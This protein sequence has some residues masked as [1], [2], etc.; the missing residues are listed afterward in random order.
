VVYNDAGVLG[1][2]GDIFVVM[3][4][5]AGA[6]WTSPYRV[7]QDSALHSQ[8]FPT[9]AVSPDGNNLMIAWYD[10]RLKDIN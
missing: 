7:N 4:T 6:T 1:D 2:R 3:S 9:I 5:D 10:R 8:W